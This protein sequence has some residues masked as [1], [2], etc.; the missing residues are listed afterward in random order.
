ML[1]RL[2]VEEARVGT[3]GS[4]DGVGGPEDAGEGFS[5]THILF[6]LAAG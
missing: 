6:L 5:T 2:P 4:M 1:E 3:A